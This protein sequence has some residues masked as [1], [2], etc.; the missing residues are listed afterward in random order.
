MERCGEQER[1]QKSEDVG[2]KE[3]GLE[4]Q[5]KELHSG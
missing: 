2:T 4:E 1:G 3:D 5:G